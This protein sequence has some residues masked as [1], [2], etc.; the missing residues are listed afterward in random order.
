M[1]PVSAYIGSPNEKHI[2]KFAWLPVRSKSKKLIWFKKYVLV[3]KLF[4]D[5]PRAPLTKLTWDTIFTE[6]EY[7]IYL[8]TMDKGYKA[9]G[10]EFTGNPYN[11]I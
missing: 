2:E 4:D 1:K 3:Q 11:I 7:T 10:H 6:K 8:L 9:K 5:A